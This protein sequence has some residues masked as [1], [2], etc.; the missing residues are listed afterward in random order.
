MGQ[1]GVQPGTESLTCL[2]CLNLPQVPVTI[3]CG[4]SYC[5]SCI[6]THWD[7]VRKKKNYRCPHCDKSF[8][9]RPVLLKDTALAVSV[10]EQK[11]TGFKASPCSFGL[12]DVACDVCTGRKQKASKSCLQCL[13]SYCEKH[14][15]PHSHSSAFKRHTLVEPSKNLHDY[16]CSQHSKVM[17]LFC[18][19]DQRCICYCCHMEDHKGHNV[20]PAAAARTEKQNELVISRQCL[21]QTTHARVRDVIH[22]QWEV[23]AIRPSV[24]KAVEHSE[25]MFAGLIHLVENTSSDVMQQVRSQQET[26]VGRVKQLQDKLEHEITELKRRD[27]ELQTLS[28]TKGHDRFCLNHPSLSRLGDPTDSL[29]IQTRPLRYFEDVETAVSEERDKLEDILREKLTLSPPGTTIRAVLLQYWCDI[30]LDP[31]TASDTL[32]L[33]EQNRRAT[34]VC[35]QQPYP[36]HP[37]RFTYWNQ[38]L[39]KETLTGRHYWEVE[40]KGTF[41]HVGVTY[42]DIKRDN[43][44]FCRNQIRLGYNVN[45]WSFDISQSG[46][47]FKH[48]QAESKVTDPLTPRIGVYLDHSAGVLSFFRVA[49][50]MT[51]LHRVQTTF[52]QPLYAGLGMYFPPTTAKFC[53]LAC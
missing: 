43:S 4:H 36:F 26:E 46:Y 39:G 3:P 45:S 28:H 34:A 51:L 33:S 15:R 6:N 50:T 9:P 53:E 29:G 22:L 14:L 44:R 38:V 19:T 2:I 37:E 48:D 30:T 47:T 35:D 12:E 40:V 42:K 20:V 11:K 1:D 13:V 23:E 16:V 24:V 32:L 17:K 8:T 52:T 49:K 21:Q 31:N 10:E 25:K 27:A 41:A 18:R 7:K 5:I